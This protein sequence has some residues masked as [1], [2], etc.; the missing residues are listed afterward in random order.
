MEFGTPDVRVY[1]PFKEDRYLGFEQL[2][3]KIH[4][5]VAVAISYDYESSEFF[6][7][8]YN[9]AMFYFAVTIHTLL[10]IPYSI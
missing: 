7:L 8:C 4:L 2:I 5:A 9:F 3:A 10:L 1:L 6:L